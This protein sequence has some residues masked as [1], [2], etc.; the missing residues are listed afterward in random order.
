MNNLE[1]GAHLGFYIRDFSS[2][3]ITYRFSFFNKNKLVKLFVY[4][5]VNKFSAALA[6]SAHSAELTEPL[7][8][9]EQSFW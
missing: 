9:A 2:R 7:T 4:N 1:H 5:S 8:H 6:L 3:G